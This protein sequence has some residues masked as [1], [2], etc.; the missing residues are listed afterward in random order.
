MGVGKST[1]AK[2]LAKRLNLK[3]IDTDLNIEK[4]C[5]DSMKQQSERIAIVSQ[6]RITNEFCK[7]LSTDKPSIGLGILQESGLMKKVFPEIDLMYG[8]DQ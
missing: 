6:E 5:L 2:I 7:I 3:F 4:N 1:L 8:M